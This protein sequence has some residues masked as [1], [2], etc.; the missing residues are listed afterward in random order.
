MF[1]E[2]SWQQMFFEHSL[3]NLRPSHHPRTASEVSFSWND[4]GNQPPNRMPNKSNNE[5]KHSNSEGKH[6]FNIRWFSFRPRP[7][8]VGPWLLN[9][10][11]SCLCPWWAGPPAVKV[12]IVCRNC[13]WEIV[14]WTVNGGSNPPRGRAIACAP[15]WRGKMKVACSEFCCHP[16]IKNIKMR[17]VTTKQ[18][19]SWVLNT[20]GRLSGR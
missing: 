11:D 7:M 5:T 10:F 19:T 17:S 20:A 9:K 1:F 4:G 6:L 8:K 13:L 2:C 15:G 12:K 16:Y 18:E 14:V 3:P